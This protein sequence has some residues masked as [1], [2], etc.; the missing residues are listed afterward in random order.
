MG[1]LNN[2]GVL[3][4][5]AADEA[6]RS[7]NTY[8]MVYCMTLQLMRLWRALWR[9]LWRALWR[10]LWRALWKVCGELCGEV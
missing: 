6:V 4:D 1:W 5:L 2:H 7:Y 10:T 8:I 9:T 3:Y